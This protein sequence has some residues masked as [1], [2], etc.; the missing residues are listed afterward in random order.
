[1]EYLPGSNAEA[2][3]LYREFQNNGDSEIAD[4]PKLLTLCRHT[5]TAYP[6]YSRPF[7]VEEVNK[8]LGDLKPCKAPGFDGIHPDFLKND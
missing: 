2:E 7:T 5:T 1:M 8:T 6:E 3:Q 4:E